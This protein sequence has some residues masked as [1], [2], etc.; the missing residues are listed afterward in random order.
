[1]ARTLLLALTTLSL[2]LAATALW[3]PRPKTSW[4]YQIDGKEIDL[5]IEVQA[6]DI[7]LFDTPK[8]TIDAIHAKGSY[9][10]CYFSA[11]SYENWR[12]DKNDFPASALG[13]PLDGW[14]G[15][16][17]LDTN[18][19]Q[20]RTIMMKR[21]DLAVSKGCDAV[22][23][24]NV[25]GYVQDS[26]F[27]LTAADTIDYNRFIASEAHKRNLAVGLKNNLKQIPDLVASFDFAVN[28]Q[29]NVYKECALLV[30]FV[31]ANKAVFGVEYEEDQS[32]IGS[33]NT[34]CT[35]VNSLNFDFILK[36]LD[37]HARPF[38]QCRTYTKPP[39]PT[40]SP[41]PA[42]PSASGPAPPP[43]GTAPPPP[44]SGTAPPPPPSPAASPV[45]PSF[46]STPVPVPPVP[47]PPPA[48]ASP[49]A[50]PSP[51]E[52]PVPPPRPTTHLG[53]NAA[54]ALL[55]SALLLAAILAC[56]LF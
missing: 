13:K 35:T 39:A 7:D 53:E 2:I 46:G 30:P 12:P 9:A 49:V 55:P 40:P 20:V 23:P 25:D 43:S 14:E 36:N 17:W 27:K 29:C 34:W 1:M 51:A 4:Q 54:P 24:D 26:G 38:S 21:M 33:M 3:Q 18:N 28:E 11:G 5:T 15:E 8:S 45:L 50:T 47:A 31:Q 16:R 32:K 19:A 44:P 10:I 22:E 41:A 37:L 48:P 42:F 6:Y 52:P 56:L